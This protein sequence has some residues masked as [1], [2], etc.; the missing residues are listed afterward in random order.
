MENLF[1]LIVLAIIIITN[2][3]NIRKKMKSAGDDSGAAGG[4]A[5][6]LKKMLNDIKAEMEKT[7][8]Q[9]PSKPRRSSGWED[10]IGGG[11]QEPSETWR[12][13]ESTEK[14]PEARTL[15][16]TKAPPRIET[17]APPGI[18]K[19]RRTHLESLQKRGETPEARLADKRKE[20]SGVIS[21][22]YYPKLPKMPD[23]PLASPLHR[24]RC[25]YSI[26]ELQN[27][28]I[29]YEILGKPVS[30]RQPDR[31]PWL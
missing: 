15:M 24:K 7:A 26:A 20:S 4:W 31:E 1:F 5:K 19:G 13:P 12:E 3:A 22:Q 30:L 23:A 17:K 6:N 14:Q 18:E 8:G 27:A 28:V 10:L 29:W 11:G 16:E 2:V 21:R 25:A 9:T